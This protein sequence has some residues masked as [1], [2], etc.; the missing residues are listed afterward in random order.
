MPSVRSPREVGRAQ[1]WLAGASLACTAGL[2]SLPGTAQSAS[3]NAPAL[4]IVAGAERS[5]WKEVDA[6]G[7]VL[8]REGGTLPMAGLRLEG[9]CPSVDWSAQ[10]MLSHGD[11]GYDGLTNT[12]TP[13]QSQSKL[14]AQRL[15][16]QVWLPVGAGW[17]VGSQLAY[18]GMDRSIE[19]RGNVRGYPER[20]S[21]LQ[22]ALGARYQAALSAQT[23][24]AASLWLGGGP[25][26]RV[27]VELP[28]FDPRTLPLGSSRMLT[29]AVELQ[30]GA[31]RNQP[32]WSWQ[33][34]LSYRY[35]QTDAGDA[36]ILT[37]NALPAGVALQPRFDQRHFGV[38]LGAN[39]HF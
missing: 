30:G 17:S 16:A 2:I 21:Y 24:W 10:W 6:E 3:C 11:R 19:G 25:G 23:R 37:R 1:R 20:F 5:H 7:R 18:V 12:Q 32:G 9:Q 27:R 29:I 26:G 36:R 28:R 39:Y 38:T 31:A 34:S 35:E 13:F 22:A 8:V 33:S 4:G 14:Q 15:S